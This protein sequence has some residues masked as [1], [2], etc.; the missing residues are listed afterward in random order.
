MPTI[1]IIDG[2]RIHFYTNEGNEPIHIHAQKAEMDCKYWINV[3]EYDIIP[4]YEYNMK[5]KDRRDIRKIIFDHFDYIVRHW[6]LYQRMKD[7]G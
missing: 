7:N 3:E 5:V 4:A 1:V 2:W 6:E